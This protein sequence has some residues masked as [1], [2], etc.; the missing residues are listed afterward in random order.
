MK[1]LLS[2][3]APGLVALVAADR[4]TAAP[5]DFEPANLPVI[6]IPFATADY[7]EFGGVGDFTIFGAEGLATGTPQSGTLFFDIFVDFTVTDR[8]DIAGALFSIDDN[9]AFLDGTLVQAGFDADILQLLFGDLSG[10]AAS[11]F[12]A[13]A[14]VEVIFIN[15]FPGDDPLSNLTDGTAY[16]VAATVSAPIPLPAALPLLLAGLGGLVLL[17][18]RG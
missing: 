4:A 17:R 2:A 12:G 6:D 14:L 16:D 3:L 5:I 9:G 7:V 18:R 10:S 11:D 15:P 1:S 13:R 8:S